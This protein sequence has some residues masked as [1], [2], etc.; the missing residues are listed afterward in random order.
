MLTELWNE[1]TSIFTNDKFARIKSKTEATFTAV[2]YE[3]ENGILPILDNYQDPKNKAILDNLK[4][5][6]TFKIIKEGL[7]VNDPS[8]LLVELEVYFK[9]ILTNQSKIV[10]SINT[11]LSDSVNEK[12]ITFKQ[13]E[14]MNYVDDMYS[15]TYFTTELLYILIRDEKNSMLSQKQVIK[16]L[17]QLPSFKLKVLNK[18]TVKDALASIANSSAESI[19]DRNSADAPDSIKMSGIKVSNF[20][21]NPIFSFRKWLVDKDIDKAKALED[22][23]NLIELRLLELRNQAAGESD[24]EGL[25]KQIEYYE[26]KLAEVD[27]KISKLMEV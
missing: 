9:D 26:D 12:T 25:R 1:I 10:S 13:Y 22:T 23:K 3:I 18:V 19:Y 14:M 11:I 16:L 2:V 4:N 27:S 17:K 5:S 20:I 15:N 21:G 7:K 8:K 24:N 6:N